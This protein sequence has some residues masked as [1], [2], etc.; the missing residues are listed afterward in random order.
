MPR[1]DDPA[2]GDPDVDPLK[3]VDRLKDAPLKD[4]ERKALRPDRRPAV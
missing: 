1:V 2:K 3:D 4:A